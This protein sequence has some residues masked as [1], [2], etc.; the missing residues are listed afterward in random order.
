MFL[1]P[2][3]NLVDLRTFD[4]RAQFSYISKQSMD[5]KIATNV[6]QGRPQFALRQRGRWEKRHAVNHE[7]G[8]Y[9]RDLIGAVGMWREPWNTCRKRRSARGRCRSCRGRRNWRKRWNRRP[10]G[11]WSGCSRRGVDSTAALLVPK[12]RA[13]GSSNRPFVAGHSRGRR[14]AACQKPRRLGYKPGLAARAKSPQHSTIGRE[15]NCMGGC[16]RSKAATIH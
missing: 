7:F 3:F 16:H 4:C 6:C 14:D 13:A 10:C 9:L 5:L 1:R 8:G 11:C 15:D 12:Q 2:H